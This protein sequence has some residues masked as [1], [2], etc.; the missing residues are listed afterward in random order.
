MDNSQASASDS[1]SVAQ[2]SQRYINNDVH[3][4]KNTSQ[5]GDVWSNFDLCVMNDNQER[6][7]CKRCFKFLGV[8]G[9][10][11]LR[12]HLGKICQGAVQEDPTQPTLG[13][14]GSIFLYDQEALRQDLARFV[15]QQGLPFNH[16]DN[17][18]LT[19]LIQNRLQPRYNNVS[20]TTLRRDAFKLWKK[21]KNDT[22][23]GFRTYKHKVSITC[24]VWT[25]PHGTAN[26]YLAVTAHWFHPDSWLLMKRTIAFKLFAYP[27]N[28]NNLRKIIQDTLIEYNLIDKVFTISLDNTSNNTSAMDMLKIRMQ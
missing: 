9:N 13:W 27:H 23:E 16:F 24:T 11:T 12:K 2:S 25:A 18:K 17:P 26:S 10:S 6:A 8:S 22:T 21:A 28:G 7:R 20:R 5:K 14:D 19:E 15:I 4:I 3:M 1:A